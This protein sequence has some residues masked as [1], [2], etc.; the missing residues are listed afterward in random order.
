MRICR[1]R[2]S[3]KTCLFNV[4]CKDRGRVVRLSR[5]GGELTEVRAAMSQIFV[6]M[7]CFFLSA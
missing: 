2:I 6:S 1:V 7:A 5:V 4:L 3:Q